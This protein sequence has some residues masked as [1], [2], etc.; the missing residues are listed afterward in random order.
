MILKSLMEMQETMKHT[1]GWQLLAAIM[2]SLSH[3]EDP[4]AGKHY[5]RIP[6]L[7]Y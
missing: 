7:A 4:G 1:L 6:P 3:H 2:G 5:S